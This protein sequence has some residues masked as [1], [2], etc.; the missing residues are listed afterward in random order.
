MNEQT[1]HVALL[2]LGTV[3]TGVYKVMKAQQ[4]EMVHKIGT[5]LKLK[6][7][8]V[9]NVEKAAARV[10]DPSIV[11]NDWQSIISDPQIQIVIE[12]MGGLEPARTYILEALRAGKCVVTANKDLIAV[13]GRELLDTA[14]E[15][16]VS[17][18]FEASVAGGIPIIMPLKQSLIGNHLTEVMGIVNGTTNYILSKMTAEG[19][20][21][22][23]ALAEAT[24]LGYAEADPTADIEGYDAARKMA[25]MA[26]IAFNS[27][28]TF[29][30]VYTEGITKIT[31]RDIEY[32]GEMGWQI[33]LLGVA[34][35]T[36]EGIEVRV[37][38]MLIPSPHPL[39]TVSG[40]YN[41]VFV[42]GDAVDDVMFYGRGAGE[43]PTASAIMGDVMDTARDIRFGSTG[44]IQCTCYKNRPIK[45]IKDIESR[46]FI[47]MQV[48]DRSG[49]LA[50][51]ASVFGNSGVSIAQVIQ[52]VKSKN[53]A[54]IVVITEK[55][56]EGYLDDALA[57]FNGMSVIREISAVI[58]VYG[59]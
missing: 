40:S 42:H 45:A 37:H 32:A 7:I 17:L 15:H 41:A 1:I 57:I 36:E 4:A 22:A 9:R 49:A 59:E 13:S 24:R 39:A 44:H 48:E 27:R 31:S 10:D 51:V 30:D 8:L 16:G 53:T 47:R 43:L 25:I 6:K 20:E 58:R 19:M 12:V 50:S 35:D 55:V 28:V 18:M 2:G 38:P 56:K 34:R 23:D 46:Y 29:S 14:A 21:F 11:T 54:E 5:E 52:K 3:G 33:K 26:S